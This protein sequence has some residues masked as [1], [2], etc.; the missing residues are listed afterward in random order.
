[1]L[2]EG[3]A[4]LTLNAAQ[5][6]E[7]RN[8]V[9]KLSLFN[10]LCVLTLT[11][12]EHRQSKINEGSTFDFGPQQQSMHSGFA[13]HHGADSEPDEKSDHQFMA[14]QLQS[15]EQAWSEIQQMQQQL[16]LQRQLNQMLREQNNAFAR[17]LGQVVVE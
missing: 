6:S 12:C 2:K 17:E 4:M 10:T 8:R 3:N 14:Q 15:T 7:F 5:L 13:N 1:M 16:E 11:G 9:I